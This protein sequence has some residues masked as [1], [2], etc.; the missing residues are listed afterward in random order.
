MVRGWVFQGWM[1][2]DAW[3]ELMGIP[4]RN[5]MHGWV[6]QGLAGCAC[7]SLKL[8]VAKHFPALA[9][10]AWVPQHNPLQT[11]YNSCSPAAYHAFS[12]CYS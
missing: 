1:G 7:L 12:N 6:F 9:Q 11:L 4:E 2:W 8:L 10:R 5:G 3:M